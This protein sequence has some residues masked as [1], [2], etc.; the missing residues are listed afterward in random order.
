MIDLQ[1][2]GTKNDLVV[3]NGDLQLVMDDAAIRQS[4]LQTL[5]TFAGEWFLDTS[6][7]IP[8]FQSIFVRNPNLDLIQAYFQNAITNVP[9]IASLNGFN[10]DYTNSNRQLAISFQATSTNGQIIKAQA[11]IGA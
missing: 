5:Q 2:A 6:V 11:S 4:V 7:G 10:F 8:Y 1:I 9:G 3:S